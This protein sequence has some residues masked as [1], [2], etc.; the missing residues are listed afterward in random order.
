MKPF[1]KLVIASFKQ[2]F[3]DRTALFFT[4]AFPLLF[5]I[6]F[7]LV[8]SGED[9]IS[10]DI[11]LVNNDDSIIGDAL[12]QSL[13]QVPVFNMSQGILDDK[14]EE[15][16]NGDINA[17][18]QIPAELQSTINSGKVANITLFYD[19]SQITSSQ[20]I[21]SVLDQIMNEANHMI[22]QQPVVI[23]LEQEPIQAQNLSNIDYLVP[24]ILAMSILFL[25]LFGALPMVEW[26]EKEVLKRL[27][28]TPLHRSTIVLS[29]V[30][31]RLILALIQTLIIIAVAYFAFDVQVVGSWIVLFGLVLLGTLTFVSIGYLAVSRA[32]TTEGAMPIIQLIQFPMLFLS[33][34]F[35]PVDFMPDFTRPIVNALPLTY[36]GDTFRQVMVEA[37]PLHSMGIN[38]AVLTGWFVVSMILA[39]RFFRWE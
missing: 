20:V 8:F 26:R 4:F 35:F 17:V 32:R 11:G 18:I 3:R 10:Y 1:N 15:L 22:T 29:Q 2:F 21:L 30:V 31:Y 39:I 19:P 33:G 14:L 36:L 16:R 37:T 34:V 23:K 25:G 38:L 28:A 24:G 5:M 7:G 9:S 27:G 6:I 12:S 13:Q